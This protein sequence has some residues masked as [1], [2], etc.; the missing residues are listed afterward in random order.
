MPLKKLPNVGEYLKI[1]QRKARQCRDEH[2][3]LRIF[4]QSSI[5]KKKILIIYPAKATTAAGQSFV[6]D[7]DSELV[8]QGL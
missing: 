8:C 3:H 1:I 5:H 6:K 2:V 4:G 7:F